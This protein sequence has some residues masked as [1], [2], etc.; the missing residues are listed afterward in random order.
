MG[1]E[2]EAAAVMEEDAVKAAAM[3]KVVKQRTLRR[4]CW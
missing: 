4:G 1:E 3:V 2:G